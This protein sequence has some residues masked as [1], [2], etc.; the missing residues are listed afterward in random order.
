[1]VLVVVS[2]APE[3]TDD[4]AYSV[5]DRILREVALDGD[6]PI[7]LIDAH[8]SYV[9]GVGD[10][11]YG[12][13]VAEKLVKDTRAAVRAA[14]AAGRDGPVEVGVAARG[15]YSI[16]EQGIGPQGIRALAIRAGGSTTGY[17]LIDGNNLL[18]GQREAILRALADLVDDAEVLTTDNHV[19]HEVDGGI[20]PVGERI[21]LDTLI[22]EAREALIS[23]K[24]DLAPVDVRFGTKEVP[25]VKILGPGLTAR[26]L[27]SLGDTLSMFTNMTPATLLLLLTSS[28]V[29]AFA[30]R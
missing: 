18:V 15:G 3:P 16:G 8:N 28:L 11:A 27:T 30:I 24:G 21:P 10:I 9:E 14:V 5:A 23:A 19:V 2:Q 4:I 1:M 12:T 7:A 20:N 29:V 17:V 13:P 22:H 26:L 6:P 25:A